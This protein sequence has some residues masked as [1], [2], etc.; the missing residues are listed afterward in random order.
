MRRRTLSDFTPQLP[1]AVLFAIWLRP[2]GHGGNGCE[3]EAGRLLGHG[4]E[5]EKEKERKKSSCYEQ[6]VG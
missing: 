5:K 2:E 3:V 4:E 6:S 1:P